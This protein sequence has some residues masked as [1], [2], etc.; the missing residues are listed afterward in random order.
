VT[1][2]GPFLFIAAI[3]CSTGP[4]YAVE[5]SAFVEDVSDTASGVQQMDILNEGR[6]IELG[7]DTTGIVRANLL[8][9][10][11]GIA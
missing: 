6:V 11:Y 2:K 10:E 5:P 3:L 7:K 4:A 8:E 9:P 1:Q